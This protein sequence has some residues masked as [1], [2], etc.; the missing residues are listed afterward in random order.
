MRLFIAL[1]LPESERERIVDAIRPLRESRLP[2]RWLPPESLH[3]TMKFL[4]EVRPD[5]VPAITA[6]IEDAASK[7][8]PFTLPLGGFGAFP[9]LRRPRVLWLG[10][11]ATPELRCL[12]HD[13]EWGL[14][15]HGY[16]REVRAFM[17]HVTLGRAL[18]DAGAGDFRDLPDILTAIA[19]EGAVDVATVDL[20]RSHLLPDGARYEVLER[21]RLRSPARPPSATAGAPDGRS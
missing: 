19:Y 13:L 4:G 20:M 16:E 10:A 11:A 18:S 6:S 2:V 21:I 8:S 5:R 9:T 7:S 3:I 14:A 15:G 1:N 12:K 17:P